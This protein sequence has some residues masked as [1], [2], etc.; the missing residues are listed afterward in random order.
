HPEYEIVYISKG[1]RGRR[2]IGDHV[3]YY[4]DG[5]L[6][7]LGPN[8]PHY[9]F[10]EQVDSE[11]FEIVVQLQADFL[12]P[13]FFD[14]PELSGIRQ[15]FERAQSGLSFYGQIKD[16]IGRDLYAMME[17]DNFDRLL[18]LLRILRKLSQAKE[19]QLLNARGFALEV[20]GKDHQRM[21]VIHDY[22]EKHY[23]D[24]IPLEEMAREVQ[25]TV[26]SFCRY[27][28]K[29]TGKT[30]THFVNEFR[31]TYACRLLADSHLSIAEVCFDSG[32]NNLSHFN[33]HFKK[34]TGQSPSEYR[35]AIKTL[36]TKAGEAAE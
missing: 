26:P 22:V 25:M 31:V 2:H 18:R 5:D 32:F 30:F 3:S 8:L 1:S 24:V 15:L 33:K 16:E 11:H 28:K 21:R 13:H 34:V 36:V 27:L 20:D 12:G 9:G 23:L 4:N 14:A 29:L 7:F 6:I 17:M 10:S 19:Y 35:R